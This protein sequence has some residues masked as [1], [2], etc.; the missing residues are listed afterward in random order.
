MRWTLE[1]TTEGLGNLVCP[2]L[3]DSMIHSVFVVWR[4]SIEQG[5]DGRIFIESV[6]TMVQVRQS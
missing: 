5:N 2:F 6:T 4:P 1:V 3:P